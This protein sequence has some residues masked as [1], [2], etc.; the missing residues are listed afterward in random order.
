MNVRNGFTTDRALT[1]AASLPPDQAARLVAVV[2]ADPPRRARAVFFFA[3]SEANG[4][5][6][7]S[8]YDGRCGSGPSAS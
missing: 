4:R 2:V 1:A 6:S 8:S 7:R 3:A 5:H